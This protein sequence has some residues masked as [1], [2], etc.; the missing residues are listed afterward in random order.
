MTTGG[1]RLLI[2]PPAILVLLICLMIFQNVDVILKKSKE[3]FHPEPV[4][5]NDVIYPETT[6]IILC[7]VVLWIEPI[8]W[9]YWAST[10]AQSCTIGLT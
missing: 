1:S 8:V 3:N 9:T 7:F 6:N 4:Q 2:L 5:L 10:G